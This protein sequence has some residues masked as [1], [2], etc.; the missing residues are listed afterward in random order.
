MKDIEEKQKQEEERQREIAERRKE[1][2]K[3]RIHVT[4]HKLEDKS[5][6]SDLS[7]T[8]NNSGAELAVSS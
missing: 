8:S 2:L 3:K 1:K 7:I 5:S 6:D 4:E